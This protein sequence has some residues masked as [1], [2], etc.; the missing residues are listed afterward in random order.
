MQKALTDQ[1]DAIDILFA[2]L[3]EAKPGFFPSKS[4]KPWEAMQLGNKALAAANGEK[5]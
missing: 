3:I 5:A 2:M 4:G 1:H